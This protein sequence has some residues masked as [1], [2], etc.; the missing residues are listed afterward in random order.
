MV[1]PR[2]HLLVCFL[3][4]FVLL[5][6]VDGEAEVDVDPDVGRNVT[7]LI[8][9]RGYAVETHKVTTADRYVL[10]MYRMPKSYDETQSGSDPAVNKPVVLLQH[11]LIDS[12]FTFVC[13]FRKQ[14][15]AFIL[16]DAGYDVW[17]ANNRGNTWSREHLDYTEDDDEFWDFTWEDMG[18][19]DLPAEIEYVL[20]RTKRPTLSFVGQSQGSIQAFA[21]FSIDQEMAKKVSYYAALTPVAWTGNMDAKIFNGMAKLHLEKLFKVFDIVEFSP[22]SKFIQEKL[23]GFTCTV[24]SELCDSTLSLIMSGPS[25]SMNTTRL[26]VY[27][28]QM[29]AGTSVKNMA[30]FAQSIRENTFASYDYGC[31]CDRDSDISECSE[32]ECEN[33][34]VYGSFDPPAIPIGKMVYPRTGL[35]IGGEDSIAT[36]TD[37]AQL[38]SALPSGTIVHELTVDKYTHLDAVWAAD[39]YEM[40]YKDLLVQLK[41]YRGVGYEPNSK[42]SADSAADAAETGGEAD[43]VSEGKIFSFRSQLD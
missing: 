40:M 4:S 29:P 30:H 43:I 34:K 19:Y 41:K 15:L 33:K 2:R 27:L 23:G 36:E 7:E 22:K 13:N 11:G 16:A 18:K 1:D 6:S 21:G 3:W 14:S 42:S 17:L 31:D 28:S 10:T 12:S 38:R 8:K 35:Y 5:L 9:A 32:S 24:L 37:I 20:K 26:P 39:T 25:S